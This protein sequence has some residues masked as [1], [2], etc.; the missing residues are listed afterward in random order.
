M[1]RVFLVPGMVVLAAVVSL[2]VAAAD[3]ARLPE[4]A[5]VPVPQQAVETPPV[6]EEVSAERTPPS[7][8]FPVGWED[9][10][11]CAGWIGSDK[12]L[13]TG[14]IVA[15][16]Y[17]DSRD[18]LGTGDVVYSDVGA[19]EGLMAGQVFWV[20]RPEYQ[21]Y[22]A[23]SISDVVGRFYATPGRAKVVCVQETTA[24]LEFIESCEPAYIG[25]LLIPFEPIPIPLVRASAPLTQ[26]D[27]PSGKVTGQIVSVKDRA[28]PVGTDSVVFLD[29]GEQDGLYP[30]DFLTIYR[31]RAGGGTIRTLLGEAA[32]LW[33]KPHTCVAKITSMVDSMIVGDFAELK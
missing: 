27:R 18:M 20:I 9:D 17:E 33:T 26:C 23:G 15:A 12:E 22:K 24:I 28:T 30:G 8:P 5:P 3:R 13:V 16:E 7:A 10:V 31:N 29:L 25:D 1:K 6:I 2:P 4:A 11:Y 32:V 21:V 14:R 19:R